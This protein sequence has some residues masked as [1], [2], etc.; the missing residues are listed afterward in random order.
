[1]KRKVLHSGYFAG[2]LINQA[3]CNSAESDRRSM[4]HCLPGK[5][6][7]L[8]QI[9]HSRLEKNKVAM[10]ICLKTSARILRQFSQNPC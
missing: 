3:L 10:W 5:C 7:E 8:S 2:S 4:N 9:F 1:M 6:L